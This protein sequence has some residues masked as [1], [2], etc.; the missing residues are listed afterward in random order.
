MKL[1]RF[2]IG[3]F[4]FL[5]HLFPYTK[6]LFFSCCMFAGSTA[7]GPIVHHLW[8][9]AGS[10]NAN[11]FFAI[12]LVFGTAQVRIILNIISGSYSLLGGMFPA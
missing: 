1:I 7:L 5:R 10:A 4:P 2:Q 3:F 6:Q 9:Y 11:Y 8:V 12:N